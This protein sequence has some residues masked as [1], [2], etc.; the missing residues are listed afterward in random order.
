MLV[1]I[2]KAF[3]VYVSIPK[4]FVVFSP[5]LFPRRLAISRH[6]AQYTAPITAPP[7]SPLPS[8]S[9]CWSWV[10]LSHSLAQSPCR[11]PKQIRGFRCLCP[12]LQGPIAPVLAEL[13]ASA[14]LKAYA[15]PCTVQRP[16]APTRQSPSSPARTP[17]NEPLLCFE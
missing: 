13:K 11:P 16:L 7:S 2:P 8:S 17:V 12:L 1:P 6:T 14:R 3:A 4:A 9:S 5:I 15:A 10:S